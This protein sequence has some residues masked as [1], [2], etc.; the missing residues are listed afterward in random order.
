MANLTL[1][2]IGVGTVGGA[3]L[4]YWHR[5]GLKPYIYDRS[6]QL[7]APAEVNKADIVF[8]CVPTPSTESGACNTSL[9][10]IAIHLLASPKI[11]VIKSTVVPGTT[12][13][14]QREL[15]QHRF[16]M[17]PEFL[18]E[19]TA[20]E[21]TL[22]PERQLVGYTAQSRP[23]AEEI[24]ALLPPAPYTKVLPVTAVEMIKYFGNTFLA[25]KVMLA[26]EVYD[27]CQHLGV[28]YEAVAEAVA[29][30][31]RI[32][33]SHLK[34]NPATQGYDGKCLPKDVSALAQLARQLK[35]GA[36][37]IEAVD[38]HNQRYLKSRP[39]IKSE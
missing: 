24:L 7:G 38:E 11:V 16:L 35:S 36:L 22:K 26:N 25:A 31:S 18:R 23:L 28:D 3:L 30:D 15:P 33:S 17:S 27:L 1:G 5:Q 14:L 32:G 13:R 34:I 6:K 2:L 19:A 20:L 29:Y 10:E 9:V 8:I 12:E 39:G 37:M 21:D 4:E